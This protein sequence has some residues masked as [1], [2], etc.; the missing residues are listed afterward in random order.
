MVENGLEGV[1]LGGIIDGRLLGHE[2]GDL[3]SHL[4][5]VNAIEV[6]IDLGGEEF[7]LEGVLLGG[8]FGGEVFVFLGTTFVIVF[9]GEIVAEVG[10]G[11]TEDAFEGGA[12]GAKDGGLDVGLVIFDDGGSVV[13]MELE[14]NNVGLDVLFVA[15]ED[16]ADD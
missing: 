7:A 8:G 3:V 5:G 16:G 12:V 2:F 9:G 14:L 6:A 4:V 1:V 11:T 15:T 13:D 10:A